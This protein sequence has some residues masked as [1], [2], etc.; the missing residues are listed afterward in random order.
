MTSEADRA[1]AT[2]S[3]MIELGKPPS[4]TLRMFGCWFG[5]PLDN[6]H[7][8]VAV[9]ALPEAV[10]MLTFNNRETLRVWNPQQI[11]ITDTEF[12][13]NSANRVR[14]D[15]FYYGREQSY[16]N[17]CWYEFHREGNIVVASSK[18]IGSQQQLKP[19]VDQPAAELLSFELLNPSPQS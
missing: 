11:T 3:R 1:A 19:A 7:V 14:W 5:K 2:L 4:G 10:L 6:H 17:L 8:L 16:D 12:R 15:W 13:I 18:T 9:E